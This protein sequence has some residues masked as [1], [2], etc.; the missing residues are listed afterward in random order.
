MRKILLFMILL[1]AMLLVSGCNIGYCGDNICSAGE[2]FHETCQNCPQD[3]KPD[4]LHI[5]DITN[6][7]ADEWGFVELNYKEA[8]LNITYNELLRNNEDYQ[9]EI[10]YF[11]GRV[12]QVAE[13]EGKFAISLATGMNKFT[14]NYLGDI[15]LVGH[16]GQ[17]VLEDDIIEVWGKV[18]PLMTMKSLLGTD[19]TM[20]T[21]MSLELNVIKEVE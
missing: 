16:E 11:K 14:G 19:K 15:V 1:L 2:E 12:T 3:C 6:P 4:E 17:R 9:D 18:R 20:P 7:N 8:V 5:C 21:I 10:V 13:E